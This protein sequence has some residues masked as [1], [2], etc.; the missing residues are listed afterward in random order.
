[1]KGEDRSVMNPV[2][3]LVIVSNRL[4]IVLNHDEGGS[5]Q[6]QEGSGGLVSALAPVLKNRGGVWIGW[7]GTTEEENGNIKNVLE[8]ETKSFGYSMKPVILTLEEKQKYYEGFAN[9]IIWP[10]FH[11][12]TAHCNFNPEYWQVYQQVNRK[13][14]DVVY[15]NIRENDF[16]WIHDY[17]LMNIA[18]ELRS[19]GVRSELAFFLHI[20][21]PP[22]DIMV[23]LPWRFQILHSLLEFNLIGFQ[24]MRDRRNFI[25]CVKTLIPGVRVFGKGQVQTI[26]VGEHEIRIGAFPIGIDFHGFVKL[27]ATPEVSEKAW[28]IHEDLTDR[29]IILGVDRLDYTKGIPERLKA[30]RNALARYPELQENVTFV[31]AVVPSRRSLPRYAALKTEIERLV[32]EINGQF[33]R[34]GWVPIHYFFR[35]L[36][37]PELLAYYRTSEIALLTPLKD[38]MN[39]VAKEYCACKI[40]ENGVLILS[41]FAGAAAQLQKYAELVNP[42][43]IEGIAETIYRAYKMEPEKRKIR[44]RRLRY[45]IRKYDIF[46]WVDSFLKAAFARDLKDF[47]YIED[48]IP[49]EENN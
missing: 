23:R 30:Y 6:V 45:I 2:N 15:Q 33:T 5:W 27:A 35:S 44:M 26:R 47:P 39:L 10:L 28:F 3:R 42:H 22:L 48:Y 34:S 13:F 7:P 16:I 8:E 20:P 17:H 41:E 14:A 32:G 36:S 11:D 38:G 31:Q 25:H 1:M 29:V 49:T 9:E 19:A 37:R 43:D 12:M 40:E 24:T 21:F 18:T 4:P 46:W